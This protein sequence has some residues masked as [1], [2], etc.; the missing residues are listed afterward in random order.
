MASLSTRTSK[1]SDQRWPF[2]SRCR[3]GYEF[4]YNCG[5]R[6]KHCQCEV[7][8]ADQR[9]MAREM[10]QRLLGQDLQLPQPRA[11]MAMSSAHSQCHH[12]G[13]YTVQGRHRCQ[14]CR[15]HM[16]RFILRCGECGIHACARCHQDPHRQRDPQP[17]RETQ[18]QRVTQHQWD[19]Q[20]QRVTHYQWE[21]QHQWDMHYYQC[22]YG[23]WYR[24]IGRYR[25]WRC[26]RI[27]NNFIL[28]CEQ[29]GIGVC[30][31]C[32]RDSGL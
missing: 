10:A 20:P 9:K 19:T 24:V 27:L 23:G 3:C 21:T 22:L 12:G 30:A 2:P 26:L 5:V 7:W 31:R 29:C 11:V 6:W 32:R 17:Q 28:K 18:P 4:C 16:L 13:W 15:Q 25:C 8:N 1:P 14:V